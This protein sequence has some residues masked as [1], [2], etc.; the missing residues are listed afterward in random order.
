MPRRPADP[1]TL[2][3]RFVGD[4]CDA[5]VIAVANVAVAHPQLRPWPCGDARAPKRGHERI[6]DLHLRAVENRDAVHEWTYDR[7]I[8]HRSC[9]I[10]ERDKRCPRKDAREITS[11]R[12]TKPDSAQ[13]YTLGVP[14]GQSR[15]WQTVGEGD[16]DL[17]AFLPITGGLK[18]GKEFLL[19]L[20]GQWR[21]RV[22]SD[23]CLLPP[24]ALQRE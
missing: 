20:M 9:G 6:L 8:T 16:G 7:A 10:H 3:G 19:L 23:R 1:A 21:G 15:R 24:H 12:T 17:R 14:Y 4:E 5:T 18:S 2:D 11:R 13:H 22:G